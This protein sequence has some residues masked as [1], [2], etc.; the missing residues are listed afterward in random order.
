MRS[1]ITDLSEAEESGQLHEIT[2]NQSINM[3]RI[4]DN[5]RDLESSKARLEYLGQWYPSLCMFILKK[6]GMLSELD[7]YMKRCKSYKNNW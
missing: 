6:R 1:I 2:M 7:Q 3:A 5:L 4:Q